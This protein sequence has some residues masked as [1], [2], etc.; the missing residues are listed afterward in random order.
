MRRTLTILMIVGGVAAMVLSYFGL[1]APWGASDVSNS[2]PRVPFA[3]V[4]FLVGI[5]SIFLAAVVYE[6]LPDRRS[7]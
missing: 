6:V 7:K 1:S 4:L 3:P 2:D 5:V